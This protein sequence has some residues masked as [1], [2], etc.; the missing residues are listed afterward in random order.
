MDHYFQYLY[1]ICET[2][3]D[4]CNGC[5]YHFKYCFLKQVLDSNSDLFLFGIPITWTIQDFNRIDKKKMV[6]LEGI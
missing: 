2:F 4:D 6:F 1:T 3:D 5:K